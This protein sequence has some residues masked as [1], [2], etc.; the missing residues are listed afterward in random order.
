M[1]TP[2][3]NWGILATGS[4]ARSFAEHLTHSR[5]GRLRAVA[6]R[7]QARADAF[8][9]DFT[10][11]RA[12][13]SY[14]PLLADPD[15]HAVYISTPHPQH[16]EWAVKAARAKK[17]ILCEK[18]LAVNAVQAQA[19]I[20]AARANDVFLMEAFM[21]RCHPQTAK[22][23]ELLREGAIGQVR[24]IQATFSFYAPYKPESRLYTKDLAG[25]GILDVGCYPVSLSRL[26]AGVAANDPRG[27]AEPLD[28]DDLLAHA[29]LGPGGCDHYTAATLKFP[30]DILAQLAAGVALHQ[31]NVARIYGTKGWILVPKPWIAAREGGVSSILLYKGADQ[32]PQEIQVSCD[33][34][35]YALEA[36]VVAENLPRRQAPCP[37]MSWDDTLGNMRTLDRW[38][39]A[40]GL[41]YPSE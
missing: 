15:V 37:C 23:V 24:L 21:Y 38:R 29:H 2:T 17:H 1:T 7:S 28:D 22:L 30:N 16:L 20:D 6:S 35:I 39:A 26:V 14:E 4:I 5:T 13:G 33:R 19:I 32:S 11:P 41:K 3:L 9:R 25:G 31:D 18:P 8:A 36:D 40:I 12:Y 27:F 34:P 10:V